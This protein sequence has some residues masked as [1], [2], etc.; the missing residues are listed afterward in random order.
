MK[1]HEKVTKKNYCNNETVL[2]TDV[3]STQ[4]A[5]LFVP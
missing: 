5:Q 1:N 4:D 3:H 2:P